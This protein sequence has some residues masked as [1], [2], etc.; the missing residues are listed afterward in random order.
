MYRSAREV[1]HG[2][3]KNATEGL[4]AP[5]RI[6]WITALLAAGQVLPF[7]LLAFGAVTPLSAIAAACAMAPRLVAAA[8]FQQSWM[9]AL[10]HPLGI[11]VLLTLQ[12]Y[13]CIRALTGQSS[14]WKGRPYPSPTQGATR[15][16]CVHASPPVDSST[17]ART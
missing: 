2:M 14:T 6:L 17:R 8:R 11:L 10:L 13:A 9:S 1:W 15:T 4:A 3:A 7:A 12:W 16:G 5:Q